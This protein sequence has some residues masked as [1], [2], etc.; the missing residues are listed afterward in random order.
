MTY[1]FIAFGG[2]EYWVYLA[3]LLFARGMDMLSTRIGTPNLVLEGNPIS[4]RLGWRGGLIVN[5]VFCVGVAVWPLPAI[6]LSTMSALVAARNFQ[7]AWLM[8][9]MGERAYGSWI[10]QQIT[11]SPP[12][13]FVRCVL[14]Q[15]GLIALVGAAVMLT[16]PVASVP[17]AIGAGICGFALANLVF[18]MLSVWRIRHA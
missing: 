2:T 16:T 13:L 15:S 6:L 9:A 11:A 18:K 10:F 3:L 7:E 8:R 5:L 4:K 1:Q 12:G 14:A 17:F